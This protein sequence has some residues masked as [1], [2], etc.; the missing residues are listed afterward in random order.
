MLAEFYRRHLHTSG[1]SKEIFIYECARRASDRKRVKKFV[2]D[3][4][5]KMG[6]GTPDQEEAELDQPGTQPQDGSVSDN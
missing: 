3:L 2:D 5:N 6:L 4:F 1:M